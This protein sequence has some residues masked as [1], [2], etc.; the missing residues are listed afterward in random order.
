[1]FSVR[2]QVSGV[3]C[4]VPDVK[5]QVSGARCQVSGARCQVPSAKCQVPGVRCQVSGDKSKFRNATIGTGSWPMSLELQLLST[6]NQTPTTKEQCRH[7][8][9]PTRQRSWIYICIYIYIDVYM[10]GGVRV[11]SIYGITPSL[12]VYQS[13]ILRMSPLIP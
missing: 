8:G 3:R 5:C 13:F 12:F 7:G 9:G 1:M 10:Y 2:C 6:N 11:P 4:Q